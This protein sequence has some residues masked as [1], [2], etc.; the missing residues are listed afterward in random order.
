MLI[1]LLAGSYISQLPACAGWIN[2]TSVITFY[3]IVD[4]LWVKPFFFLKER[5]Q[6]KEASNTR[7]STT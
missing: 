2:K 6:K 5:L 1:K 4:F 7:I 3:S